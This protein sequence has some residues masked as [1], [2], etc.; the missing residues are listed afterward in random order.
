MKQLIKYNDVVLDIADDVV[1]AKPADGVFVPCDKAEASHIWDRT[2]DVAYMATD[3][4]FESTNAEAPADWE[5]CRYI[6]KNGA[7]APNPDWKPAPPSLE[8]QINNLALALAEQMMINQ[9]LQDQL[10]MQDETAIEL[11]EAQAAQ[12]EVNAMQD[13]SIIQLYEMLA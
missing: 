2:H 10:A 5:G 8:E 4:T 1:Y 3:V 12:E 6:Y 11:Y 9:D 7:F 13:E